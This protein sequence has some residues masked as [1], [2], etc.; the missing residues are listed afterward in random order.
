LARRAYADGAAVTFIEYHG[1]AAGKGGR[2]IVEID[3]DR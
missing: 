3:K 1:V 2:L